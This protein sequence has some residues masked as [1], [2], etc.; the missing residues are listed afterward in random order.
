[1]DSKFSYLGSHQ[2][3]EPIII[4]ILCL[5]VIVKLREKQEGNTLRAVTD[6]QTAIFQ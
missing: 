2:L 5:S 4:E 6:L 3:Y 1:M